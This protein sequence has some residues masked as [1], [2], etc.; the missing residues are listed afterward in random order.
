MSLVHQPNA[1]ASHSPYSRE[2]SSFTLLDTLR[3]YSTSLHSTL[4]ESCS[5]TTVHRG[6]IQNQSVCLCRVFFSE[7]W[8]DWTWLDSFDQLSSDTSVWLSEILP[9]FSGSS[10]YFSVVLVTRSSIRPGPAFLC[11]HLSTLNIC[12]RIP[13]SEPFQNPLCLT[14]PHYKPVTIYGLRKA[15]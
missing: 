11:D 12:V 4:L 5:V 10:L 6:S 1:V 14:W 7:S 8:L 15:N 3:C 13:R 2:A 9:V